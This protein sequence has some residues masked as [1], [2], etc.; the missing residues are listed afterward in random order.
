MVASTVVKRQGET[1]T[2]KARLKKGINPVPPPDEPGFGVCPDYALGLTG[3]KL[4]GSVRT[5]GGTMVT[6]DNL[7][8]DYSDSLAGDLLGGKDLRFDQ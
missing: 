8:I 5:P 6:L 4:Q 2:M 3:S 1:Y 7:T